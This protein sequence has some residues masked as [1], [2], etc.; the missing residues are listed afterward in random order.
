MCELLE[1]EDFNKTISTI[2]TKFRK[3]NYLFIAVHEMVGHMNP[4]TK[5]N[6]EKIDITITKYMSVYRKYFLNCVIPKMHFSE[7][8]IPHWMAK[9][10][11]GMALHGE[12]G[13]EAIH[14]E[15]NKLEHTMC[16][17]P[18][19]EKRLFYIMQEHHTITHPFV[20]KYI[21]KPRVA[22]DKM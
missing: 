22:D 10:G 1:N 12:Q 15:F 4:A 11:F 14:R 3:L 13:D 5:E 9:Y 6:L 16:H 7:D 8:H 21:I 2:V 20:Q 18:Q 17:V 19:T